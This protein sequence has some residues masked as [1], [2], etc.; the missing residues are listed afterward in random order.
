MGFYPFTNIKSRRSHRRCSAREVFFKISQNSHGNTCVGASFLIKLQASNLLLLTFLR[1]KTV[2]KDIQISYV[3]R[4]LFHKDSLLTLSWRRSLSYRNQSIDLLCKTIDW[5][6]NDRGFCHERV[7]WDILQAK[8]WLFSRLLQFLKV[9]VLMVQDATWK[10]VGNEAKGQI[11][12]RVLQENKPRQIFR[13]TNI[14][15]L[16][17][18]TRTYL[19]VSGGRKGSF[20]GKFGELF[21][22]ETLVLRFSLLSF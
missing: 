18:R 1:N 14:S 2:L 17:I 22:L 20:Y 9:I 19:C 8:I 3:W 5:F 7:K 12:K 6:L 13:K 4:I 16:L 11:S 15:Y 10:F 21:F